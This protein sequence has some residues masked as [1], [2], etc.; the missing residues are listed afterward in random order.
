MDGVTAA[1]HGTLRIM[2]YLTTCG[3]LLGI[4][5]IGSMVAGAYAAENGSLLVWYGAVTFAFGL[6]MWF[7][8]RKY[9]NK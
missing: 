1:S 5:G 2:S 8:G 4:T 7:T 6:I 9:R 3:Y